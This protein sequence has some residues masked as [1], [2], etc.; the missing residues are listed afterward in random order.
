MNGVN[1]LF[2]SAGKTDPAKGRFPSSASPN[3]LLYAAM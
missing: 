2:A 1:P 3:D